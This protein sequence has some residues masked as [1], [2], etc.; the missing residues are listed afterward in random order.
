MHKASEQTIR[1][2]LEIK[3]SEV[4]VVQYGCWL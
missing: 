3:T 1:T 4:G 2:L